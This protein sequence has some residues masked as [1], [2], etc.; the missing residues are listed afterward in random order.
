M[1]WNREQIGKVLQSARLQMGLTQS[2]VG[3]MANLKPETVS[4]L[5]RGD[6]CRPPRKTTQARLERVLGVKLEITRGAES[7]VTI[8]VP[9]DKTHLIS[10]VVTKWPE[11]SKGAA[12]MAALQAWSE[13]RA[14]LVKWNL[15][16]PGANLEV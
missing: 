8:Y 2:E 12:I 3:E 9:A 11:K 7:Y 6:Q 14:A 5:E 13:H 4:A 16:H 10:E 1:E 15:E